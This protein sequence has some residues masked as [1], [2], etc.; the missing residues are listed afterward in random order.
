MSNLMR[1]LMVPVVMLAGAKSFTQWLKLPAIPTD[2]TEVQDK[3][4]LKDFYGW[5]SPEMEVHWQ[6]WEQDRSYHNLKNIGSEWVR[7]DA[8]RGYKGLAFLATIATLAGFAAG[9]PLGLLISVVLL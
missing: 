1:K 7:L 4:R 9:I 8:Q 3:N 2:P 6:T 5:L